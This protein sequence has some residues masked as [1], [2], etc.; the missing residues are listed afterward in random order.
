MKK[1]NVYICLTVLLTSTLSGEEKQLSY[2]NDLV[3][4][5]LF[6]KATEAYITIYHQSRDKKEKAKCLYSLGKIALKKDNADLAIKNWRRLSSEFPESAEA[7]DVEDQISILAQASQSVVMETI[8]SSSAVSYLS[9]GD[10]YS[11]SDGRWSIDTSYLPKEELS[12][13]WYERAIKEFPGTKA[14]ELALRKKFFAYLGWKDTYSAFGL[15]SDS[16]TYLPKLEA[17]INELEKEFPNSSYLAP[18]C[19]Q[20]AQYFWSYGDNMRAKEWLIKCKKVSGE[21]G[22][23]AVLVDARL[24]NYKDHGVPAP[25]SASE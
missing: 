2:A 23:Y 10:F 19:F 5:G 1:R 3:E 12:A 22:Y 8:E 16:S 9:N 14:H 24:K 17:V 15:K 4:H 11:G 13:Y 21:G 18:M 25:F 6:D 7:R 20:I